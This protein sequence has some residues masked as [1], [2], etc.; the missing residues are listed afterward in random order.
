MADQ[1][2]TVFPKAT[3][4]IH[5]KAAAVIRNDARVPAQGQN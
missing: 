4:P 5:V 1:E 2:T 3:G